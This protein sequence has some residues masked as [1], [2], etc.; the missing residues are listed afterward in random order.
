M[1]ACIHQLLETI[2]REKGLLVG[3]RSIETLHAFLSGYAY[4][5]KEREGTDDYRFLSEFGDWVQ[6]RY[7]VDSTQGWA[8]IVQFFSNEEAEELPLFWKL[9][10]EYRKGSR[11]QASHPKPQ[12]K[13]V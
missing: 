13:A 12:K 2:R 8:K 5:R 10:D 11:R 9:Y 7:R 6:R 1:A 3:R 4:A